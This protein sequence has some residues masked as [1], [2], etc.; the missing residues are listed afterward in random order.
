VRNV[1]VTQFVK[2][3]LEDIKDQ[4]QFRTESEAIYYLLR[5]YEMFAEQVSVTYYL[6]CREHYKVEK[7]AEENEENMVEKW[8]FNP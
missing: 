5:V 8:T 7:E 3:S 1:K 2:T 4:L 6:Q